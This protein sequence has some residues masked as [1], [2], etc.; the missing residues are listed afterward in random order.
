M[1]RF[2][3]LLS[4]FLAAQEPEFKI[5]VS[6][7]LVVVNLSARDRKGNA[8]DKLRKEDILLTEDGKPQ[9]IAILEFQKLAPVPLP[10]LE[11]PP[12]EK[13]FTPVTAITP[14]QPGEMRYRDRRLLVLFFDFS[15]MPVADQVRTQQA[16]LRFLDRDMTAADLVALVQFSGRLQVL[17]DFTDDRALLTDVVNNLRIGEGADLAA[18]ALTEEDEPSEEGSVVFFADPTEFNMFNTD[19]KLA[20]LEAAVGMFSGFPEKKA[21]IYFSNGAAKGGVENYSQLRATVNAAVRANVAFYP[22]DARGLVATAPAGNASQGSPKGTAIYSGKAQRDIKDKFN[23]EQETLST[24]ASDTGGRALL[25]S[26]DLGLGIKQAQEDIASYYILGYYSTNDAQDGRFRK[27]QIKLRSGLSAKLDYRP[28]YYAPKLF[29]DFDTYDKEKQLA[30]ALLLGD[31]IT[32]LPFTLEVNWFRFGLDRYFVP[33]AL[34]VPGSR[35]DRIE[36][37]ELDFS[38]QVRDAKGKLAGSVRDTIPLKLKAE[39]AGRLVRRQIEYDTGFVLEPGE[40]RVK[41]VVR[42]NANGRLGTYEAR[43]TIPDL[44][45]DEESLRLSSVVLANQ[46]EPLTAA[47]GQA[48]KPNPRLTLHPLIDSG[49]KLVPSITRVFR[50]DQSLMIYAEA[51]DAAN[52]VAGLSLFQKGRKVFEAPA[53]EVKDPLKIRPFA[54]PLRFAVPL[55]ALA[56]GEYEAQL[57]V[58]DP[59]GGKFFFRREPFLLLR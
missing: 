8:L 4:A 36:K 33:I 58:I 10:R 28:G 45:T 13:E 37:L 34:K 17:S 11:P 32:D 51:Y 43:F 5:S 18:E 57:S 29:K 2:L 21:L 44:T 35:L 22:V 31:P 55:A 23:D 39:D 16:A 46:K 24:L 41:F 6:T 50:R 7:N 20:A 59:A 53:L 47:V 27:I 14:P 42:E 38:G 26:N 25:D 52:V 54:K 15:G 30:E 48:G 40:Y 49:A 19:R 3:F 9:P 56:P 12:P 1:R